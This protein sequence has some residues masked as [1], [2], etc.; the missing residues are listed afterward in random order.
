MVARWLIRYTGTEEQEA[1]AARADSGSFMQHQ[2]GRVPTASGRL[3]HAVQRVPWSS[4]AIPALIAIGFAFMSVWSD[5]VGHA[6]GLV[7]SADLVGN[8]TNARVFSHQIGRS[9]V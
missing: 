1:R 5:L 7:E 4:A 6:S 3:V 9:H 2:T 8:V